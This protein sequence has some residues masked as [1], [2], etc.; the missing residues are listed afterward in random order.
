MIRWFVYHSSILAIYLGIFIFVELKSVFYI[1]AYSINPLFI[2]AFNGIYRPSINVLLY[3]DPALALAL[4]P[5]LLIRLY[6]YDYHSLS[7]C[8][9]HYL[10]IYY[11]LYLIFIYWS[12]IILGS[13]F[14]SSLFTLF[15]QLFTPSSSLFIFYI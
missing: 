6:L 3:L 5:W 7:L 14:S 10:N 4:L 12:Y 9:I 2:G 1:C 15:S 11:L 13:Y 8:S